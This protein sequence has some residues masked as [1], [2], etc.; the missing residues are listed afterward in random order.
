MFGYF[1]TIISSF[2]PFPT[3]PFNF[4][5][6]SLSIYT[7]DYQTVYLSSFLFLYVYHMHTNKKTP[8]NTYIHARGNLLTQKHLDI[9]NTHSSAV[10]FKSLSV[11]SI[12]NPRFLFF[13]LKSSISV[14]IIYK[15]INQFFFF[16]STEILCIIFLKL[17][18]FIYI[19]TA[20]KIHLF[21]SVKT[22]SFSQIEE[23][24]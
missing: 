2:Y 8:K 3:S 24:V 15:R 11:Q 13:T 7:S 20:C 16:I 21:F 18:I 23:N 1:F 22:L 19:F 6:L 17:Y 4:R 12:L 14:S 9:Q 10:Y 5:S